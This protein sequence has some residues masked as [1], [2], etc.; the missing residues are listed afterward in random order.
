MTG[1]G[2]AD[3]VVLTYEF[4]TVTLYSNTGF[5]GSLEWQ[6]GNSRTIDVLSN[7]YTDSVVT[8][9]IHGADLDQDGLVDIIT[10]VYRKV[11]LYD[12]LDQNQVDFS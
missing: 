11:E 6:A 10:P 8:S 2:F 9:S 5:Y 7:K 3:L 4:K 1:D 12:G